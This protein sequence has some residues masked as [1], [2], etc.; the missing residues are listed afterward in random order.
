MAEQYIFEHF[1]E[2]HFSDELKEFMHDWQI[3][4]FFAPQTVL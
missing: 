4:E 1:T 3:K 2:T